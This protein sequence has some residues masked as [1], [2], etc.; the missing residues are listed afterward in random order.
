MNRGDVVLVDWPYSDSLGT[1][2]RPAV[3]VPDFLNGL[4]DDTVLVQI[5]GTHHG[6]PGTEVEID[7]AV[8]LGSGLVK[9]CYVSSTNLLTR[10]QM[11][12]D[13][14]IGFLSDTAMQQIELC[15]K[16]VLAMP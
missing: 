16:T 15:L 1:K 11:K 3:V 10:D 5:T 6:V 13:Q 7:P 4:I 2:L 8:E 14:T 12:I 9:V